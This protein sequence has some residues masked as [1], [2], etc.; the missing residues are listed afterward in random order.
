MKVK[1]E[2]SY[3]YHSTHRHQTDVSVQ[4][5]APDI[6]VWKK[7]LTR[8]PLK[9]R[10]GWAPFGL[11]I[12]EQKQVSCSWQDAAAQRIAYSLYRLRYTG[13]QYK[14]RDAEIRKCPSL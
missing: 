5:H 13:Y 9:R 6:L 11:V 4:L 1:R 7:P 14:D 10:L 2:W 12:S 3:S 8:Y